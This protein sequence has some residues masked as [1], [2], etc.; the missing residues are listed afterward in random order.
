MVLYLN[1]ITAPSTTTDRLYN[2]GGDLFWNGTNISSGGSGWS[3]T[4][5]AGTNSNTNFIGTT[6]NTA[7][8][9]KTN[10]NTSGLIDPLNSN[11]F[12]GYIAGQS[13][14]GTQNVAIG[15]NAFSANITGS[16]N[17][18]LGTGALQ[19]NTSGTGNIAIGNFADVNS[20]GLINA[21]AIGRNAKVGAS[22]SL[23][24]GGTGADAVNVGIG[25]TTPFTRLEVREDV[26]GPLAVAFTNNNAGTNAYAASRLVT[27][28]GLHGIIFKNS[29]ARS[30]DGGINTMTVRNDGG[31]LRLQS[32]FG[33]GIFVQGATGNVGIG[34]TAPGAALEV[35][36]QVKITGGTPGAGKVLTSDATGLATWQNA[37]GSGW[38]LTGNA[39][40]VDGTNFIGTT[41]NI[42]LNFRMN[43]LKAGRIASSVTF[44]G[45][46]AGNSNTIGTNSTAVGA[47]A[48]KSQTG[49]LDNTAVGF[50]AMESFGTVSGRNTAV[51]SYAL[52]NSSGLN[53]SDNTAVGFE[54]LMFNRASSN[55]AVGAQALKNNAT[56]TGNAAFGQGALI[57]NTGGF[58]NVA[59]GINSLQSNLTGNNN[60]AIG[61]ALINNDASGNTAVGSG[62]GSTLTSGNR[63][64]FLGA[65]ADAGSAFLQDAT[66]IGARAYVTSNYSIVLGAIN[67]INGATQDTN[68]GI[69]TTAPTAKLDIVGGKL[70]ITDGTQG[71]GFLLTSDA[72][73]L[74]SWSGSTT[75]WNTNGNALGNNA[76]G[77]LGS[78]DNSSIS[79]VTNDIERLQIDKSGNIKI[80]RGI[81]I[82]STYNG[83]IIPNNGAIIEGN[84][85]VGTTNPNGFSGRLLH[86]AGTGNTAYILEK[87]DATARKWGMVTGATGEYIIQDMTGSVN[88]F[89][90]SPGGNVGIGTTSPAALLDITGAANGIRVN[91]WLSAGSSACGIGYVGTNLYRNASDNVWKFT[92]TNG[93]IGGTAINFADCSGTPN[94][95]S[96]VR[97]LGPSTANANATVIESMRIDENGRVGIG[98]AAPAYPL[99]VSGGAATSI[100]T[101]FFNTG[102]GGGLSVNEN[103]NP[104]ISVRAFGGFLSQASGFGGGFY[105]T[106]DERIKRKIGVSDSKNDL[107]QIMKIKV[108]DYKM[109]DSLNAGN[110]LIKGLIAQEVEAVYPQAVTKQTNFIPN[111]YAMAD[112][113][114]FDQAKQTLRVTMIKAHNLAV[115]DKVKLI[116]STG[117]EKPSVVASVD[118]NTFTVGN[119]TEK[120][121]KVF[122]YGKEVND[123]RIVDYDRLFTLN[124]SATQELVKLV[125]EQKKVIEELKAREDENKKKIAL[126]EAS[127][128]KAATSESE[129]ASLKS[130][131]EKIKA[132]LGLTVDAA[133]PKKE[134]KK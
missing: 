79:I 69:G 63:N 58:G 106:S 113:T 24:L 85:G 26:D 61:G 59:V 94:Q 30:V 52:N 114:E 64:T 122:V 74:A 83:A 16:G 112:R 2:V 134:E 21:V 80:I 75:F 28:Q 100:T 43:N 17:V 128:N 51:G 133:L 90:I 98:T 99:D 81:S 4:G 49:G 62:S 8:R 126:L 33:N 31:S 86:L 84:V 39:G 18:A 130:E 95:I 9:F 103:Q 3:L 88:A 34:T 32:D 92:N 73:G 93:T 127:L 110:Q 120:S 66:A 109:R 47:S 124:I 76:I 50:K 45:L 60:V 42:P 123:F 48:L 54:S 14:T 25:T 116:S 108:T 107:S 44:F 118:G 5:N 20:P 1:P 97:A 13:T 104:T 125:E 115:G 23:I 67:G 102:N 91:S 38:G 117:G 131:I 96:F 65:N 46:E 40:T 111:V 129:L 70:K 27:D 105:V 6:D 15:T 7:L 68:V 82:G 56:G 77:K 53:P 132:A 119:W 36:G 121:E 29:S 71:A 22:N 101:T 12:F 37:G 87:T 72:N 10:N 35:A 55:T 57:A 78:T 19:T 41:D 11:V 89:S